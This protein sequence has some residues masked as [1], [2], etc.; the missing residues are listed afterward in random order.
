MGQLRPE[1]KN[2]DIKLSSAGLIYHHFGHEIIAAQTKLEP[3][4]P[5]V[6]AIFQKVYENFVREI[7]AID[8][9]VNMCDGE[10]RWVNHDLS[11]L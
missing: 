2:A 7:D 1:L 8:N 3:D 11:V 5:D 4:H 9:G 6:K 10:M